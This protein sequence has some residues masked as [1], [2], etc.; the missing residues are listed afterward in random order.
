[1]NKKKKYV[2]VN[3][4]LGVSWGWVGFLVVKGGDFSLASFAGTPDVDENDNIEE[5]GDE[6]KDDAAKDPGGKGSQ[7]NWIRRSRPKN[8]DKKVDQHLEKAVRQEHYLEQKV[9]E[10]HILG[11]RMTND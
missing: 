5:E 7:S 3:W 2:K 1:M 4:N 9:S 8:R 11:V 6:D 10:S